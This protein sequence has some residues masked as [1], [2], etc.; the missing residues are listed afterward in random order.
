MTVTAASFR[1]TF[2]EFANVATY[3]DPQVNFWLAASVSQFNAGRWGT[4]LDLGVSLYVAHQVSLQAKAVKAA[5]FGGVPGA[6][7]GPVASKG[8]DKVNVSYDTGS[9][10]EEGAGHWNMTIYGQ[11]YIRLARQIG[12]GPVQIDAQTAQGGVSL[13]TGAWPGPYF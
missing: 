7:T 4:L 9:V 12:M 10:A 6:A 2:P 13:T 3:P 11:Q 8:V 5:A 1:T